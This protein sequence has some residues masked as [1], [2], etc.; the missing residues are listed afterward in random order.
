MGKVV[1]IESKSI[2]EYLNQLEEMGE[3]REDYEGFMAIPW[4]RPNTGFPSTTTR[5]RTTRSRKR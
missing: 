1:I 5:N 3:E 2:H 4:A